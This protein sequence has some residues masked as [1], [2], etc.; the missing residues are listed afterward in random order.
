MWPNWLERGLDAWMP[1]AMVPGSAMLLGAS[2]A[3]VAWISVPLAAGLAVVIL[4]AALYNALA[5]AQVRARNALSQIDVQLRR[6]H[7]LIPNLVE[8]V[9]GYMEHERATL[10]AVIRARASA[11][12]ATEELAVS[13]LS[14]VRT[15]AVASMALDGALRGLLARIEAYPDLKAS[16]VMHALQEELVTTENR[17]AFARQAFNDSV[18]RLNERVVTFPS[19]LVAG[20]FGFRQ[21]EL[22]ETEA[23]TRAAP[24]ARLGSRS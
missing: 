19:N 17:V 4:L 10:E 12:A 16:A 5:V 15:L 23:D 22:W 21:A 18:M 7:D 6:R 3:D 13:G 8:T 1:E 9:R 14:G 20:W 24:T 11:Q 2:G